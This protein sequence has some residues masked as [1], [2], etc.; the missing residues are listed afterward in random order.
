MEQE[1]NERKRER[2]KHL[3]GFGAINGSLFL[4]YHNFVASSIKNGLSPPLFLFFYNW[5]LS[6]NI[7]VVSTVQ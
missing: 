2:E 4:F 1:W 5:F 7:F 3:S 6:Y